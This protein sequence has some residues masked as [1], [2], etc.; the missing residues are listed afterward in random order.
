MSVI[1]GQAFHVYPSTQQVFAPYDRGTPM[2]CDQ[3]EFE[4]TGA[5]DP[6][7]YG[8]VAPEACT[9]EF[10]GEILWYAPADG[11]YTCAVIAKNPQVPPPPA[12]TPTGETAGALDTV[13]RWPPGAS[14]GVNQGTMVR[15]ILHLAV[16]DVVKLMPCIN[17]G[18]TL[19][20]SVGANGY[21]DC[22]FFEG[23]VLSIG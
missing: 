19:T 6:V 17:T 2:A 7:Q 23:T 8:W 11:A 15:R 10:Y 1:P 13:M 14:A 5:W 18:G 12:G 4:Q 21:S 20:N 3:I 16:G 22:N 9:V